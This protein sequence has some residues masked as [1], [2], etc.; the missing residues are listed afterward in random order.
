MNCWEFKKCGREPDGE[1][2]SVFGVCTVPVTIGFDTVNN[3]NNNGNNGGCTCWVI[4]ESSCKQVMQKCCVQELRE[5]RQCDFYVSV[6]KTMEG[7]SDESALNC[8]EFKKC[9]REP[10]G[11]NVPHAGVCPVSIA[12]GLNGIHN[13]KNGGRCC[14]AFAPEGSKHDDVLLSSLE[15]SIRCSR[16]DFYH[17]VKKDTELFVVA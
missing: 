15:K 5:C 6:N 2:V 16:C 13:G 17:M 12:S 1:N 10:N 3:G 11:I 4:R 7:S 9:G 8:W 14:W